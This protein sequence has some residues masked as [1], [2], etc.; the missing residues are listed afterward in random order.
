M[1]WAH[2]WAH[3]ETI[4]VKR[5]R[6]TY[7]DGSIARDSRGL[8]VGRIEAGYAYR[9]DGTAV[10]KRLTKASKSQRVVLDWMAKTKA[11]LAR[12]GRTADPSITVEQW[13]DRW[14]EQIVMPRRK[15]ATTNAY[16]G[17]LNTWIVPVVGRRKL[18]RLTPE[19]VRA[20]LAAARDAG[21]QPNTLRAIHGTISGMLEAAR[22]EGLLTENVASR[23]EPPRRPDSARGSLSADQTREL[24]SAAASAPHGAAYVLLLLTGMR[25]GE[26]LG[27]TW[28]CVDLDARRVVVAWQLRE[29]T[30][31]HGCGGTCGSGLAGRCPDRIAVVPDGMEYRAVGKSYLLTSTKTGK[32]RRVPL[33]PPAAAVLARHRAATDGQP[34]PHDLVFHGPDGGPLYPNGV[35]KGWGDVMETVGLPRTVTPHWA[36]HGVATLLRETGVDPKVV[37][38]IVGHSSVAMTDRYTHVSDEL[39][40]AAM[41]K[42]AELVAG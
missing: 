9:P 11:D 39:A 24:L 41:R 38:E 12:Y 19:H 7:G 28:S 18:A 33:A 22:R 16:R 32:V 15:P 26:V 1:Q 14:I 6:R 25:M 5:G 17:H 10:R 23:V 4:M 42:L 20:V 21:R 27:L 31:R 30:W 3:L 2:Q 13:A 35:R 29:G 40:D 37:S 36:R 34:N 8:W